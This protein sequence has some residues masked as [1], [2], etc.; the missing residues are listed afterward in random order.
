MKH[1]FQDT[2]HENNERQWFLKY[3]KQMR[4]TQWFPPAYCIEKISRLQCKEGDFRQ[5]LEDTLSWGHRAESPGR[6]THLEFTRQ[7][8]KK[9]KMVQRK[10]SR[11]LQ[12]LP[13]EYS[14]EYW[15]ANSFEETTWGQGRNQPTWFEGTVPKFHTGLRSA[16]RQVCSLSPL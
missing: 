15:S 9:E 8:T 5:S 11:D 12:R 14:V 3:G 13:L 4:Y 10:N 2:G 1:G 7:S 6:L 16:K